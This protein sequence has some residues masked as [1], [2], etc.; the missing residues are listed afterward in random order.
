MFHTFA[1]TF[2][3][4]V[5]QESGV[6]NL[7]LL[8]SV[9]SRHSPEFKLQIDCRF[10][11]EGGAPRKINMPPLKTNGLT[12]WRLFQTVTKKWGKKGQKTLIPAFN[13]KNVICNHLVFM[14]IK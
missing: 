5:E 8:S 7:A 13:M 12:K 3:T 14:H 11:I 1:P 4:S 10:K 2:M 6:G 9:F